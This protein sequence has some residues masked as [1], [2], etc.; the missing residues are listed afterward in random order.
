M[1][2]FQLGGWDMS[3]ALAEATVVEPVNPLRGGHLDFLD[4]PPRLARF[5]QLGLVQAVNRF[6]QGVVIGATGRPNRGLYTRLGEAFAEPDRDVLRPSIS[7]VDNIFQIEN[8]FLLT[9]PG[10]DHECH[11]GD[12]RPSGRGASCPRASRTYL[13]EA[14]AADFWMCSLLLGLAGQLSAQRLDLAGRWQPRLQVARLPASAAMVT[15]GPQQAWRAHPAGPVGLHDAARY[16]QVTFQSG[17]TGAA[18]I[19]VSHCDSS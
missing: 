1:G 4:G 8:T 19:G 15:R 12:P 7:M 17:W 13:Q 2:S 14:G 6:R 16:S 5:D 10:I 11:V 18:Q 9:R 3:A